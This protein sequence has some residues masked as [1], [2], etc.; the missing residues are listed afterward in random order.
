M[1]PSVNKKDLYLDID[2]ETARALHCVVRAMNDG[3][4]SKCHVLI[5]DYHM[6][7]SAPSLAS[8]KYTETMQCPNC[9]FIITG[10]EAK[11]AIDA[12]APVMDRCLEVFE[13]WRK[14]RG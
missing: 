8:P 1:E 7:K 6:R 13:Q 12:F 11:A 9:G 3:E 2:F 14:T 10:E 4:C 5:E